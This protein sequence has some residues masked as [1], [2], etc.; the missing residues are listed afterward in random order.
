MGNIDS[1]RSENDEYFIYEG[2][3]Q[4][5][6]NIPAE[7]KLDLE[8][9]AV[10]LDTA[11]MES[12]AYTRVYEP[13]KLIYPETDVVAKAFGTTMHPSTSSCIVTATDGRMYLSLYY[14]SETTLVTGARAMAGAASTPNF[15]NGDNYNGFVIYSISEGVATLV[16]STVNDSIIWKKA[17]GSS[18]SGAF[19]STVTLEAGWYYVGTLA[20]WSADPGTGNHCVIAGWNLSYGG[21]NTLYGLPS[22]LKYRVLLSSLSA[23]PATFTIAAA[24]NGIFTADIILYY[25]AP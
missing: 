7:S 1:L 3:T 5:A 17:A 13:W 24:S 6:P 2:T 11:L 25:T 23:P 14:V 22:T 18:V 10:D 19:T 15:T 21:V 12:D 9:I 8:S 16:D 20:N 4:L